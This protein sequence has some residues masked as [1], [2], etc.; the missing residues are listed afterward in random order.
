MADRRARAAAGPTRRDAWP[1]SAER[2]WRDTRRRR[3]MKHKVQHI[4]FVGIGGAGMSGIAEVLLEPGLQGAAAPISPTSAVT[5]RLAQL[6]VDDRASAIARRTC[7]GADVVVV[8]TRRRSRQ[9]RSAGGAR[10]RHPGRAAR[11]DARRADA[12]Q[13]GHRGRRHA[14]QDD[15]HQPHRQRARRRRPRSDVRHRRPPDLGR[16]QCAARHRRVPGRRGRRIG[17]VVPATCS[18]CSRSSPT[19]TPITWRR[20]ATTSSG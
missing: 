18:R 8:S 15:D 16:R 5:E 17:R 3:R 19:S 1:T 9:S 14:R 12:L 11:A 6:G 13:A 20:T 10:A 7:G 2:A 4:H